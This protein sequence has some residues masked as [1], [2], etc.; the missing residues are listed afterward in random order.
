M[1]GAYPTLGGP[2][3]PGGKPVLPMDLKLSALH[4]QNEEAYDAALL[5]MESGDSFIDPTKGS[6]QLTES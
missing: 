5:L 3:V 6:G 4:K 2:G 1:E